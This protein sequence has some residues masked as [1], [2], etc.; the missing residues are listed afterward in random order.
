MGE[1]DLRFWCTIIALLLGITIV[2]ADMPASRLVE[3]LHAA[4][5][6]KKT[7][8][9][10][11]STVYSIFE[12]AIMTNTNTPTGEV[13]ADNINSATYA[14]WKAFDFDVTTFWS[15]L[16]AQPH[17]IQYDCGAG[18]SNAVGEI[19]LNTYQANIGFDL[20]VL[21]GS[22]DGTNWTTEFSNE[23]GN[24]RQIIITNFNMGYYRFHRLTG[25]TTYWPN[26]AQYQMIHMSSAD[27]RSPIMSDHTNG[28]Y[29]ASADAWYNYSSPYEPWRAFDESMAS[30]WMVQGAFPHW[31]QMDFGSN[32]VINGF[33]ANNYADYGIKEYRFQSSFDNTN[34]ITLSTGTLA[35]IE[36]RQLATNNNTT[37]YRYYRLVASNG[38]QAA[39]VDIW[40][41]TPK[42][43]K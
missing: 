18:V 1:N 17:W 33:T 3:L 10:A 36:T 30:I 22:Q 13:T 26:F 16:T 11:A 28:T 43:Y 39:Q 27:Y 29:V 40:E 6:V 34:W 24:A 4:C 41:F 23:I 7:T 19:Y 5:N 8:V 37:A 15:T 25:M 42:H 2:S 38:Y 12:S 31:I 14:A 35:N 9:P 20:T 32:V 21:Q